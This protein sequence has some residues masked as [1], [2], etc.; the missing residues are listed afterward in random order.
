MGQTDAF[1]FR[2]KATTLR[3]TLWFKNMQFM[4]RASVWTRPT[5]T[6]P[7]ADVEGHR[8][9]PT[10]LCMVEPQPSIGLGFG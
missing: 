7:P 10:R 4:V 2:Q 6:T 8:L 1:R 3:Y 5:P 9:H